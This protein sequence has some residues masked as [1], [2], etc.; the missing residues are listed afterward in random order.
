MTGLESHVFCCFF[1]RFFFYEFC[2]NKIKTAEKKHHQLKA[3]ESD[4][5][6]RFEDLITVGR[7]IY[8]LT[9]VGWFF[10]AL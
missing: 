9:V 4:H 2:Q 3:I 5:R 1:R 7:F 10:I 6:I 8:L